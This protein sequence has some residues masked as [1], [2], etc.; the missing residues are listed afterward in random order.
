MK[1]LM[2]LAV[3]ALVVFIGY[4][5]FQ[6]PARLAELTKEGASKGWDL[7]TGLFNG[8]IDFLDALFS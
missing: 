8:L 4:W 1:K 5:M 3:V 2:P 7:A 6:D